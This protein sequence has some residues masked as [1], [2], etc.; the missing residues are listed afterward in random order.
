MRYEAIV[1][2]GVAAL[3]STFACGGSASDAL[4][5]TAGAI[6]IGAES[7]VAFVA[8]HYFG[9]TAELQVVKA[10]G[11]ILEAG[12]RLTKGGRLIEGTL[13]VG[14]GGS[15]SFLPF[16]SPKE[17]TVQITNAAKPRLEGICEKAQV[18]EMLTLRPL[19]VWKAAYVHPTGAVMEVERADADGIVISG[20]SSAGVVVATGTRKWL[21]VGIQ[22]E[23]LGEGCEMMNLEDEKGSILRVYGMPGVCPFAG[24]LARQR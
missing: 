7:R 1:G 14:V 5:D 15:V 6:A 17:C 12:L 20:R 4:D 19:S 11:A 13:D 2:V 22:T 23:R 18:G 21:K 3:V 10:N 9:P 16:T 8:G 24:T